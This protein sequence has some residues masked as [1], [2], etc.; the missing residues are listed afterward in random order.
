MESEKHDTDGIT[1]LIIRLDCSQGILRDG[2][3]VQV[4]EK[5]VF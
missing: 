5:T 4:I 3:A 1:T 2:N